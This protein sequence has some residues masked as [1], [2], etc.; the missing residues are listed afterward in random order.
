MNV[1]TIRPYVNLRNNPQVPETTSVPTPAFKGALGEKVVRE[2]SAKKTPDIKAIL[3]LA[4]GVI[5]LSSSKVQDIIESL[6]NG[7]RTEKN[8]NELLKEKMQKMEV[9]QAQKERCVRSDYD[10]R[11]RDLSR[12]FGESLAAKDKEIEKLSSK[13]KELERFQG[14]AQV[15]SVD[16]ISTITPE[17]IKQV[18]KEVQE[19]DV[20]AQN[21]L[22]EYLMTGK[23]QEA[24]LEQLDRNALLSKARREGMLNIPEVREA[25]EL[26]NSSLVRGHYAYL[27]ALSLLRPALKNNKHGNYI[28]SDV[29]KKQV[30]TNANALFNTFYDSKIHCYTSVTKEL[31]DM[32]K[33]YLDLEKG[34]RKLIDKG[35]TLKSENFDGGV[36]TRTYTLKNG[37]EKTWT[38]D[39]IAYHL[40][41]YM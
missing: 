28:L 16:E 34:H 35:A 18:A 27:T 39:N 38:L 5:G 11:E 13:V 30:E 21:S 36:A 26:N 31:E 2:I 10:S 32:Q 9:E 4:A 29:V 37:E 24:F 1:T 8:E 22:Y 14:M 25:I 3:A 12:T 23:G 6:V 40:S 20:E 7:L 15:K 41:Y 17:Q 19:H 33:F